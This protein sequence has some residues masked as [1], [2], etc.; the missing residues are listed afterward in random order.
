MFR[1][2]HIILEHR[3]W[4][5]DGSEVEST[6][7]TDLPPTHCATTLANLFLSVEEAFAMPQD[8]GNHPFDRWHCFDEEAGAWTA[9]TGDDENTIDV[10]VEQ[11]APTPVSELPRDEMLCNI[12][13]DEPVASFTVGTVD[14]MGTAGAD[15]GCDWTAEVYERIPGWFTV[16]LYVDGGHFSER[17][18]VEACPGGVTLADA[19]MR[20]ANLLDAAFERGGG[21][22][23]DLPH[24]IDTGEHR[25]MFVLHADAGEREECATVE[26]EI[27]ED[28]E[29]TGQARLMFYRKDGSLYDSDFFPAATWQDVYAYAERIGWVRAD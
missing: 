2:T 1:T 9:S 14:R 19:R 13:S 20:A 28:Y 8:E 26:L 15:C 11:Y 7:L 12:Y 27:A 21:H 18:T 3:S 5:A 17:P 29:E 6:G 25:S 24:W 22:I 16:A 10:W 23:E 4:K